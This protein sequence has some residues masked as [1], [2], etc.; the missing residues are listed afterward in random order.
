MVHG[1]RRQQRRDSNAVGRDQAVGQDDDVVA[2]LDGGFGAFAQRIERS[3]HTRGALCGIIGDVEGRSVEL[4]VGHVAERADLFEILVGEDGLAHFKTL[5]GRKTLKIE[6][7]GARAD[8]GHKAHHRFLA[9]RIDGR[10]GDLRKV[11]LEIGIEQL[12]LVRERRKRGIGAH[13]ADGFLASCRH[14]RHQ[15]LDVFLAVTEGLQAIEKALGG[16]GGLGLG[17]GQVLEHD[18]GLGEPGGVGVLASQSLFD[19]IVGNDAALFEIDEQHAARLQ[20]PALN[21]V[22]VGDVE[23]ARFR[24]ED[25]VIFLGHQIAG[26][27][28]AVAVKGRDHIA[29]IGQRHGGGAIPGLHERGVVLIKGAALFIHE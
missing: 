25:D 16:R 10:V 24:G 26:R 8:E 20:A 23:H 21:D 18:L 29:A 19:L 9:D 2:V 11:L 7:V 15:D 5:G 6:K 1:S 22:F 14:G 17:F 12:G 13:R 27:T 4:V 3:F 28:Q